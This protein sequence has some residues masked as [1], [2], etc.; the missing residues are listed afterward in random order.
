MGWK[1]FKR[2]E[3]Y[4]LVWSEPM[5]KLGAR[6]GIS[7]NGLKKACKRANVP[8]PPQGYWAKQQAGHNVRKTPLPPAT[9]DTPATVTISPPSARPAPPPIPES[10][11]G[12]IDGERNSGKPV[13]VP[14]TLAN[15]HRIIDSWTQESRREARQ[16]RHDPWMSRLYTPID[17][18]P[19]DK[20][21][22][23]ILSA[24]F[25]ALEA[26]GYRLIFG[27]SYRRQVHIALGDE[28]LELL[29]NER[30]QQLRHK[31]TDE[32]KAKLGYVQHWRQE[33][34]PTGEL[35]LKIK[36]ERYIGNRE[37][38]E[39]EGPPLEEQLNEIIAQIAGI[40][41]AIRLR[42]IEQAEALE[43]QRK[44]EDERRRAQMNRK[45]EV[46]RFRRLV[47]HSENWRLA[48]DIRAFVSAVEQSKLAGAQAEDFSNWKA[49]ALAHADSVD[50]L[51][52]DELFD[53]HV[54]DH[55]VYAMKD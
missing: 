19:L 47:S 33:K 23:R 13:K 10:V 11:T 2:E 55:Q 14:A 52:D 25:K 51:Q 7:G 34:V 6:F 28:K 29:L 37:W 26:R 18:T 45:R 17:G 48:D 15:P 53:Q 43:R 44:A 27:E 1:T 8:V 24:L 20:R 31:L 3:L 32:E 40:Y 42:R 38:R 16:A 50:P 5:T 39:S 35:V 41:E 36:T 54:S 22:L 4:E 49:W 30:I 21:R 12:K 9:A 46:I